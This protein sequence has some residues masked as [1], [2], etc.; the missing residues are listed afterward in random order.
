MSGSGLL[1]GPADVSP[2]PSASPSSPTGS[3][4][5]DPSASPSPS[6]PEPSSS[7]SPPA[8]CDAASGLYPLPEGSPGCLLRTSVS[9]VSPDLLLV[10][11][12]GLGLT[13]MLLT[14]LLVAQLR[15]R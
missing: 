9:D 5:P 6:A 2:S 12:L 3:S 8:E 1:A 10:V 11:S 7:S 4:E 15:R 14:A 13:V